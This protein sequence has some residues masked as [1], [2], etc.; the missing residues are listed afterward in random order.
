MLQ[1]GTSE[2]IRNRG[3]NR[4]LPKAFRTEIK[5]DKVC[6]ASLSKVVITEEIRAFVKLWHLAQV[7]RLQKWKLTLPTS[8]DSTQERLLDACHIGVRASDE[9]HRPPLETGA[10]S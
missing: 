6:P 10:D 2:G 9:D 5:L 1:N 7:D 3:P 4:E 8:S